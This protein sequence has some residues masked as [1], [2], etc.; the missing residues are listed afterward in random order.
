MT[1]LEIINP[2]QQP[3]RQAEIRKETIE[4]N[5]VIAVNVHA[6]PSK[7]TAMALTMSYTTL[8]TSHTD[9][10]TTGLHLGVPTDRKIC[11]LS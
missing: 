1:H 5:A 8:P 2:H 6:T 9:V 11:I 10:P 4:D 3:L 7:A